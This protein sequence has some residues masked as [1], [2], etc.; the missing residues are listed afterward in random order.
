MT[1]GEQGISPGVVD[2]PVT[3]RGVR[4][5]SASKGEG[6]GSFDGKMWGQE[7]GSMTLLSRME[8]SSGWQNIGSGGQGEAAGHG[9]WVSRSC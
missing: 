7:C 8:G 6:R 5:W 4:S 9:L 3:N 1:P 2:G